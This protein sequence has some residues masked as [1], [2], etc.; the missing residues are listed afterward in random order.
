MHKSEP[1]TVEFGGANAKGQSGRRR[2]RRRI[3]R[4]PLTSPLL[5]QRLLPPPAALP[6]LLP[7]PLL[8][9]LLEWG[10]VR[11]AGGRAGVS[12]GA[13]LASAFDIVRVRACGRVGADEP[14]QPP[15]RARALVCVCERA[16]A[17]VC[18]RERERAFA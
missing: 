8:P 2:R 1:K 10:L 7:L 13:R 12:G 4:P 16:C 3:R 15:V 5:H 6:V 17:L 14:A 9:L 11:R 18:V